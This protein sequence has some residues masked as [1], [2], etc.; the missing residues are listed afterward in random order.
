MVGKLQ[1]GDILITKDGLTKIFTINKSKP[2]PD[3]QL[4]NL[5]VDGDNTYYANGY[6]VHNKDIDCGRKCSGFV[7]EDWRICHDICFRN[8]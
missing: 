1:M 6:L 8:K 7:G 3:L 4:Y 2:I 5:I